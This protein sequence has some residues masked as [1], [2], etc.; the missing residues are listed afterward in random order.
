MR[1]RLR[2]GHAAQLRIH[3]L[4]HGEPRHCRD[5]RARR[6]RGAGGGGRSLA[7]RVGEETHL[8]AGPEAERGPSARPGRVS[9]KGLPLH[10]RLGLV[11]HAL[12][13]LDPLTLRGG[14]GRLCF[15]AV[16]GLRRLGLVVH[17]RVLEAKALDHDEALAR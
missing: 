4:D 2:L 7:H 10:A 8:H 12:L 17:R 13:D 6:A 14:H 1:E 9:T 15:G 5:R 11:L 16:Q 3:T